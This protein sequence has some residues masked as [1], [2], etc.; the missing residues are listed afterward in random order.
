VDALGTDDLKP[1]TAELRQ[2]LTYWRGKC[3]GGAIP[4]R[5][6]IDPVEMRGWLVG[7]FLADVCFDR[8]T[9]RPADIHF[10]VAGAQVGDLYGMELTNRKLSHV[11]LDGFRAQGFANYLD[12]V[13][14]QQPKYSLCRY[15]GDDRKPHR[16][17][18]LLLPLSRDGA[19]CDMLLGVMMPLVPDDDD[20]YGIWVYDA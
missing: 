11:D 15:V 17:E 20:S 14:Q 1:R 5:A 8:D 13:E 4:R 3:A 10:R 6:D 2:A 19:A 18:M 9:G 12:A 16:Y 7:T